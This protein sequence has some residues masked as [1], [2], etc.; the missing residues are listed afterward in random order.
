M[1]HFYPL[2]EG[3]MTPTFTSFRIACSPYLGSPAFRW[4]WAGFFIPH[5]RGCV[6]PVPSMLAV[7]LWYG[8]QCKRCCSG[9]KDSKPN[10]TA[11]ILSGVKVPLKGGQEIVRPKTKAPISTTF[12]TAGCATN[13]V[14]CRSF[15]RLYSHD[16]PGGSQRWG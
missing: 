4:I 10:H 13:R 6:R 9:H 14:L 15:P 1:V 16:A 5:D 7:R 8:R 3:R 12:R 11:L 2:C